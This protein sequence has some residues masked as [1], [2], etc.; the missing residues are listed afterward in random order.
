MI[1]ALV[2]ISDW[3]CLILRLFRLDLLYLVNLGFVL[4]AIDFACLYCLF[5]DC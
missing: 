3:F 2:W 4:F 1:A 5:V